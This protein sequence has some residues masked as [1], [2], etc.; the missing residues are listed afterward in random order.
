MYF[1]LNAPLP[2]LPGLICQGLEDLRASD[3]DATLNVFALVDCAFDEQF[4][5]SRHHSMRER[6]SL[7]A[8]T[9]LSG[10]GR[11][12]PYLV[13]GPADAGLCLSWLERLYAACDGKP[14]LSI[15][16][17]TLD[18]NALA[19]HLRPY[20]IARTEDTLEWPV[21]WGDT[22]VLPHLLSALTPAQHD[23]M[24][25]PMH[26]WWMAARDGGLSVVQGTARAEAAPADFDKLPLSDEA[27]SQV[28]DE[29]E[30]DAVLTQIE[31]RQPDVLRGLDPAVCHARVQRHLR[32][33][34]AHGIEAA[35][36][37][38]HFSQLALML[39]DDFAQHPEMARVLQRTRQGSDY[40]AE[41]MALSPVF[42]EASERRM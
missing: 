25:G 21:R 1:A 31:E 20:L 26:C 33:A 15:I 30:A 6:M 7:Y 27:F 24:L 13:A 23:A 12:A 8:G 2:D 41:V 40:A 3:P 17:S 32:I 11:A 18:L 10:L 34:D 19:H 37:R 36:A 35:E 38:R 5:S 39:A 28:V 4:F 22:R 42:W 9:S 29:A 16:A 14:M